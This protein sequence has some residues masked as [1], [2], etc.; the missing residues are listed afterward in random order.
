LSKV[1]GGSYVAICLLA[2]DL[3]SSNFMGCGRASS[4][5]VLAKS[6]VQSAEDWRERRLPS[7]FLVHLDEEK[8]W[9]RSRFLLNPYRLYVP[10]DIEMLKID[11]SHFFPPCSLYVSP[12]DF[13]SRTKKLESAP[14]N[15]KHDRHIYFI[16]EQQKHY[17]SVR[18]SIS[19]FQVDDYPDQWFHSSSAHYTLCCRDAKIENFRDRLR[20]TAQQV[21]ASSFQ[22]QKWD[23]SS[24]HC[25]YVPHNIN[26]GL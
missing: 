23:F 26:T 19:A 21:Y 24:D 6:G 13:T 5:R 22:Y 7:F 15:G 16:V 20:T 8:A 18:I 9:R 25:W 1:R 10:V 4:N 17:A 11:R 2:H 14:V 12:K 3:C